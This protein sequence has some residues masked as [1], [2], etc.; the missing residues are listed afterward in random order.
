MVDINE[1]GLIVCE[2]EPPD[3][4][5]IVHI[6]P[7]E[8]ANDE[9]EA[10]IE[11]TDNMLSS[12]IAKDFPQNR[13]T[14]RLHEFDYSETD[15]GED[16]N[17]KSLLSDL[18]DGDDF[19]DNLDS[20]SEEYVS[21]DYSR[22][23]LLIVARFESN[24]HDQLAVIKA[25]FSTQYQPDDDV[26]LSEIEQVIEDELKKGGLYPRIKISEDEE[27]PEQVGIYQR[28]W[29]EHWWKFHGV[30]EVETSNEVLEEI[31]TTDSEDM[32]WHPLHDA[33]GVGDFDDMKEELDED[34]LDGEVVIKISDKK[35]HVTLR[36]V[37]EGNVSI[38]E[39]DRYHVVVSGNEPEYYIES[40]SSNEEDDEEIPI[41]EGL[42]QYDSFDDITQ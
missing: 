16:H 30:G 22:S 42:E 28:S 37:V 19:E 18:R 32:D 9:Y 12:L 14:R 39:D 11:V 2:K 33:E 5:I 15:E 26:G 27:K 24:D 36:D 10:V 13:Q 38:V 20:L 3:H 41:L 25:P 34:Q 8:I 29:S 7:S 40:E 31:A 23:G 6:E 17:M 1:V 4:E 35:I 21:T